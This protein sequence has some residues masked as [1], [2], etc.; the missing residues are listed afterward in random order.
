MNYAS[1][2]SFKLSKMLRPKPVLSVNDQKSCILWDANRSICERQII[3][4]SCNNY[5]IRESTPLIKDRRRYFS[6]PSF[7]YPSLKTLYGIFDSPRR[8]NARE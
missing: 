1:V 4:I 2:L 3:A 5:R 6:S 8:S 7:T